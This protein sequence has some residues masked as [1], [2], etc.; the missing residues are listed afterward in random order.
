MPVTSNNYSVTGLTNGTKYY[1]EVTAVNTAGEGAPSNEAS[2]TPATPPGA[3]MGVSATAGNDQVSLSWSA[4]T[5][6]GGSTVS[7]YNVYLSKSSGSQGTVVSSQPSK[8]F[9]ATNLQNG[10]TY[11]FEV[12][13]VNA[14]GEGPPSVQVAA[15]PSTA[16]AGPAPGAPVPPGAPTGLTASAGSAQVSLSWSAPAPNGGSAVTGYDVYLST[17][18]GSQG[19]EIASEAATS[20]IATGL[21]NGA[22]YYFEVTAVS[23]AG[24]SPPSAQVSATPTAPP[25]YRLAAADGQV[26][27]FGKVSPFPSP[28]ASPAV[29]GVASTPD[30][31]GYWLV[32]NNGALIEAGDA[33]S[34]GS[35]SG[36]HLNS[37]IV[38]MAVSPDGR[39]YW[40]VSADGGLFAFGDA[41]FFGSLGAKRLNQPIV[42]IAATADGRGYW[43]VSADGGLFAFGD[44]HFFGSLGAKR[45]NQPIVGIAATADG[46]GYWMV[47]SDGGIFAF[48]DARFLGSLGAKRLNQ[49]IVGIAA[50]ADGRGYWM[51]SSDGGIFAFGDA[52]FFGSLGSMALHENVIGIAR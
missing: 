1:F 9:T 47:S 29:V 5:S 44:A 43:M 34:Y 23:T 15:T 41:H 32:L 45:L 35:M 28:P 18:P 52:S 25:G 26:F 40:M 39:G 2:A 17:T 50:T 8:T 4:P 19:Q 21:Q 51:V 12:T 10:A 36:R 31:N 42:G 13:A 24:Q 46:R 30:E 48:G 37:P 49:P 38:G 16:P 22:T 20:Y 11:Y 14:V 6:N 3:P 7:T 27:A 33:L